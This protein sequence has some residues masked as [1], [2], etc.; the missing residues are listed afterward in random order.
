LFGL[1]I[2]R[3]TNQTQAAT[4]LEVGLRYLPTEQNIFIWNTDPTG[5]LL[6]GQ[7]EVRS[8]RNYYAAY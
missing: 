5:M 6:H 2:G 7:H 3:L 8:I 1:L 4:L